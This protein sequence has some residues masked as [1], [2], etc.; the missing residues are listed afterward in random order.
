MK[1]FCRITRGGGRTFD[2][3]TGRHVD[4]P[5]VAVYSGRCRVKAP[6][7]GV[8]EAVGVGGEVQLRRYTV[9]LPHDAPGPVQVGDNWQ[10]LAGDSWLVGRTLHVLSVDY[11]EQV[12]ER[13]LTV[14]DQS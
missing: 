7:T 4:T 10:L 5:P 2:E 8:L 12:T 1:A 13:R 9:A 14:E 3:T 11:G 6:R